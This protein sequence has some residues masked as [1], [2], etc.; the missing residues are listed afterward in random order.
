MKIITL[1]TVTGW[2]GS[3][4]GVRIIFFNFN[5]FIDRDESSTLSCGLKG[6]DESRLKV[7][8]NICPI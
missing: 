4:A 7:H 5:H 2:I 3:S 6:K 1:Y 8:S